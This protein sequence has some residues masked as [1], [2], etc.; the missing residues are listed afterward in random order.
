RWRGSAAPDPP[1][2]R[3]IADPRSLL[4]MPLRRKIYAREAWSLVSRCA[5]TQGVK[6]ILFNRGIPAPESFG[7]DNV[8]RAARD[9]LA[10]HGTAL[11][12]YGPSLGFAPL[13]EWL[14]AWQGVTEGQGLLGNGSLQLLDFLCIGLLGPGAVVF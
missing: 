13:R 1:D 14:A 4:R 5:S 9:V 6:P 12:Q 3:P 11:L 8:V 10:E 2:G 7:I